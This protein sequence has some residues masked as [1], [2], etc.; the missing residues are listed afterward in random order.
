MLFSVD[1]GT[2]A[3][4]SYPAIAV[5]ANPAKEPGQ[6]ERSSAEACQSSNF[7]N[8]MAMVVAS[9]MGGLSAYVGGLSSPASQ[10]FACDRIGSPDATTV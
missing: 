5:W 7:P 2:P 3:A 1:S 4:P 9:L 8:A 6:A 10:P